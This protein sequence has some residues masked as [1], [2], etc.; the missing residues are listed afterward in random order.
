MMKLLFDQNLSHRLCRDL[1][2]LFPGSCQVGS[3]GLSTATDKAIWAF[4]QDNSFTIVTHDADFVDLVLHSGFP[5]KVIWLRCGNRPTVYIAS[6][7]KAHQ[8]E[9]IRLGADP[10]V[11]CLEIY[12]ERHVFRTL[13]EGRS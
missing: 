4:A 12:N 3:L 10:E 11:G 8:S 2:G 13:T 1:E 5:P 6:L 7:L 9:I